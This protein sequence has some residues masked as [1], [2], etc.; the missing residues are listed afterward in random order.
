VCDADL[1][2]TLTDSAGATVTAWTTQN[3]GLA[4]SCVPTC[5]VGGTTVCPVNSTCQSATA[6]APDCLP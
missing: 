5:V 1:P 3:P 2:T 4:G 6:A